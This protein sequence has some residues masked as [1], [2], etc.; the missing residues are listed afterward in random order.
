MIDVLK[1]SSASTALKTEKRPWYYKFENCYVFLWF[2]FLLLL[3]M[4]L[5][6]FKLSLAHSQNFS[7]LT[8]WPR[9]GGSFLCCFRNNLAC[10][11]KCPNYLFV[12]AEMFVKVTLFLETYSV[13][14]SRCSPGWP[15]WMERKGKERF[16]FWTT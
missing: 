14:K 13:L 4:F 5:E 10:S 2:R 9:E 11:E 16:V 8:D 1:E 7:F 3:N 15:P 12:V 6:F